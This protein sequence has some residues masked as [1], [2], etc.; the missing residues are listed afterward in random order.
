MHI[1]IFKSLLFWIPFYRAED[2]AY[3]AI[4]SPLLD[5]PITKAKGI[6]FNVVGGNDL[7][8]QEINAAAEVIYANVD[9]D[10][11]IIFGAMV[12]E[13]LGDQM[14]VT[15]VATGYANERAAR[16]ARRDMAAALGEPAGE[17]RIERR[18]RILGDSSGGGGDIDIPE[19]L[20][21][22]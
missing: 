22:R 12:D 3:A 10:A 15:V 11:N 5:F 13:S 21:G 7:T 8:L 19:F 16:K 1:K 4:S 6:V 20:S 18:R 2:A 14:W 9:T 17:V